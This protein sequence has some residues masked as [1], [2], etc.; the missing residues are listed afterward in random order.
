MKRGAL[1]GRETDLNAWY[2]VAAITTRDIDVLHRPVGGIRHGRL[3]VESRW[4]RR[5]V[6]VIGHC[7]DLVALMDSNVG[8]GRRDSL[9]IKR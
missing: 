2:I 5:G 8:G 4:G 6:L 3:K 1:N 7:V 9:V